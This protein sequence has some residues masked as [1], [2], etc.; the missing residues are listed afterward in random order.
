MYQ[1]LNSDYLWGSKNNIAFYFS[2][3]HFIVSVIFSIILGNNTDILFQK[4]DK[5]S[6]KEKKK[7]QADRYTYPVNQKTALRDFPGGPVVKTSPSNAEGAGSIPGL[8]AKKPKHKTEAI[9]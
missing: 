6:Y 2:Y 7:K 8:T 9:L 3:L 1:N 5:K 4:T